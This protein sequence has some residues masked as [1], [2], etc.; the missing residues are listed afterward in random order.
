[1][2]TDDPSN[3]E[4]ENEVPNSTDFYDKRKYKKNRHALKE[5]LRYIR[6]SLPN[7]HVALPMSY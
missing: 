3:W 7:K 4:S 5:Y 2:E 1:M 6:R